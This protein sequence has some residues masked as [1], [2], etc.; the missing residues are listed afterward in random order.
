M[1]ISSRRA[2]GWHGRFDALL[3]HSHPRRLGR[4]SEGTGCDRD[5][6]TGWDRVSGSD[7]ADR[8]PVRH[9]RR[10][11]GR[12]TR[13][14]GHPPT[15]GDDLPPSDPVSRVEH[16]DS[17]LRSNHADDPRPPNRRRSVGGC[18]ALAVRG[19]DTAHR[20]DGG[21]GEVGVRRARLGGLLGLGPCGE[22]GVDAVARC[23]R[24]L[25]HI[26]YRATRRA[27]SPMECAVRNAALRPDHPRRLSH[28]I[29]RDRI[30]PL[31]CR[32]PGHRRRTPHGG[33]TGYRIDRP[34]GVDRL[35]R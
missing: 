22:H 21:R 32:E 18:P 11:C 16:S 4:V 1:A 28:E 12:W 5:R 17:P 20:R 19:L 3:L 14:V 35:Q 13:A 30:D 7:R 8:Q 31:L 26:P 6:G 9:P 15:S 10:P 2:L 33:G 29:G 25:P 23:H 24:V 27:P 34:G